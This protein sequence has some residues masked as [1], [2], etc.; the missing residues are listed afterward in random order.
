MNQTTKQL[1]QGGQ[2]AGAKVIHNPHASFG[3]PGQRIAIGPEGHFRQTQVSVR[4]Q[5]DVIQAIDVLCSC[6]EKI[7]IDLQY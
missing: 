5:G 4:K 7:T 2:Q 6:G 1:S 3:T